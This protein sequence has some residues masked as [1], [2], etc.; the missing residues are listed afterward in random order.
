MPHL[1]KRILAGLGIL[2]ILLTASNAYAEEFQNLIVYHVDGYD[3][4]VV[5]VERGSSYRIEG[6]PN[7][8]S[9]DEDHELKYWQGSDG[10]S[11][12]A[13]ENTTV[14]NDVTLDAVTGWTDS[15]ESR[16]GVIIT[17]IL[18]VMVAIVLIGNCV[19]YEIEH[20]YHDDWT[21]A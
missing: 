11:Y 20:P 5:S 10:R 21:G 7:Y 16:S 1:L 17:I 4:M 3:D 19:A 18:F 6:L 9:L 13:G 8:V 14:I 2:V 15:H 12:T